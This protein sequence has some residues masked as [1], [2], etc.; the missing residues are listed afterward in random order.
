MHAM[1][2]LAKEGVATDVLGTGN[3]SSSLRAMV[4]LLQKRMLNI[5][6]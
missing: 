3:I 2:V 5:A 1:D 4:K 6:N